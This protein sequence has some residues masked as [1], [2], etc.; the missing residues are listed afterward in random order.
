MKLLADENVAGDIVSL[1][2]QRGHD[3][4]WIRQDCPGSADD[5]V[6]ARSAREQ[7][8]LLTFDKDFGELVW[9]GGQDASAGA[10]LFA[11]IDDAVRH[12]ILHGNAERVLGGYAAMRENNQEKNSIGRRF[13]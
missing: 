4:A 13:L 7:R 8:L 11:R 6:L 9:R 5:Y 12:A 10:V 3:V 1:L 2:R